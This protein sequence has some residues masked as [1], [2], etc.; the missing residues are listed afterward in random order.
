MPLYS[1]KATGIGGVTLVEGTTCKR[2]NGVTIK[3][4]EAQAEREAEA[5]RI[6]ARAENQKQK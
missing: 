5:G 2:N 6:R 1:L 4:N 3:N